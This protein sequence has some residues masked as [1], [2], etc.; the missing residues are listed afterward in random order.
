[1]AVHHLRIN[2]NKARVFPRKGAADMLTR[3]QIMQAGVLL[4]AAIGATMREEGK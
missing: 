3:E 4:A 1:M 2:K